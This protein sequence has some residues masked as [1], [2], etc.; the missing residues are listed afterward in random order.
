MF[1][2]AAGFGALDE[3]DLWEVDDATASSFFS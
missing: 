3:S 1:G 2:G